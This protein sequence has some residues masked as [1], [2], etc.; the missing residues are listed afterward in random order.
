MLEESWVRALV[1]LFVR[2]RRG[3]DAAV[4]Q[5]LEEKRNAFAWTGE[6]ALLLDGLHQRKTAPEAIARELGPF[7]LRRWQPPAS[8]APAP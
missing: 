2:D 3:R 4:A 5:V 7:F 6:L 1:V 8:P